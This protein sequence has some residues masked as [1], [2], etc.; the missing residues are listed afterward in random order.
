MRAFYSTQKSIRVFILGSPE[1]WQVGVYDLKERRWV[2]MCDGFHEMLKDAKADA[3]RR[4]EVLLGKKLA[5][6]KWH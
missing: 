4:A 3:H 1:G 6:M 2:E 5:V